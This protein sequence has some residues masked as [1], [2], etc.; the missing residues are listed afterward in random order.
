MGRKIYTKAAKVVILLPIIMD[1][2]KY[3]AEK[4]QFTNQDQPT[5]LSDYEEL[6]EAIKQRYLEKIQCIY[7]DSIFIQRKSSTPIGYLLSSLQTY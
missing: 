3:R 2:G 4:S 5:L 1:F 6:D 7:I